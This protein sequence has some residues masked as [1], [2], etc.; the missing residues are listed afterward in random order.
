[1]GKISVVGEE[2]VVGHKRVL[3]FL[4][5]STDTPQMS[6]SSRSAD[7]SKIES[8]LGLTPRLFLEDVYRFGEDYVCDGVDSLEKE[9]LRMSTERSASRRLQRVR[10]KGKVGGGEGPTDSALSAEVANGVD[11]VWDTM[12][13]AYELVGDQ[14]EAYALRNVFTWPVGLDYTVRVR[15]G[16][17]AGARAHSGV[18]C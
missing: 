14:F 13:Q 4:L 9:V 17:R 12:L 1:M 7:D 16:V 8:F 11:H 2:S 6:Q 5:P 3:P 15:A 10:G 18:E